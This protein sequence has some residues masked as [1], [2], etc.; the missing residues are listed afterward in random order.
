VVISD[1]NR[2]I[3]ALKSKLNMIRWNTEGFKYGLCNMPPVGQKYSMLS[4]A[5]NTAIALNFEEAIERFDRLYKKKVYLH[6][7]KDFMDVSGFDTARE[8][9]YSLKDEYKDL[10]TEKED[11]PIV[12]LKPLI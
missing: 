10:E 9:L 3:K 4:L 6:H 12:R 2:N 1:I 7:Y 8:N 11:R 5:N